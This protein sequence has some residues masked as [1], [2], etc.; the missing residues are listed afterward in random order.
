VVKRVILLA[1]TA[2]V[3]A[4]GADARLVVQRGIAGVKIDMNKKQ[5]RAILGKPKAVIHGQNASGS[6]LEYRYRLLYVDF[7]NSGPVSSVSTSREKERTVN[8]V[9]VGS[10]QSKVLQ[11]VRGSKCVN[12]LCTVGTPKPGKIVTTFYMRNGRVALISVGRVID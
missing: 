9:G 1:V 7:Q 11:K 12:G 4:A 6:F 3:F 8:G 2:A 5:V 10:T